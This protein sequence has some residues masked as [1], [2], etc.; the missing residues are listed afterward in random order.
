MLDII[1]HPGQ[2]V[3]IRLQRPPYN[4]ID[5][6]MLLQLRHALSE[7]ERQGQQGI[8]LS[9]QPGV[10]SAGIDLPSL[11]TAD[12]EQ[13]RAYWQQVFLLAAELAHSPLPVC[14]ALTGHAL[15]AGALLA[16]FADYR[17]MS[18]GEGRIGFSEVCVGVCLP[19]CFR[20]AVERVVG[21]R[22]AERLLAWGESCDPARALQLGLVDELVPPGQEVAQA[23]RQLE[24]LSRLPSH[25][26]QTMRQA[27][28]AS[29]REAFAD[30]N[31]LP[32]DEFVE[33]FLAPTTQALLRQ[34]LLSL[35]SQ[36]KRVAA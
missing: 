4:L 20:L 25:S 16:V 5:R 9:G 11:L 36:G 19:P 29:L 18:V 2:R 33:G 14:A 34:T 24:Q 15:A 23:L 32:V 7:A 13:V 1:Q 31:Q 28:R 30:I 22:H 35:S 17:V 8:V 10:F 6:A 21:A 26:F 3:E 27:A 12:R